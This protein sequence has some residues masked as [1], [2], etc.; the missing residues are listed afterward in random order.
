M[1][2]RYRTRKRPEITI[3]PINRNSS[4]DALVVG[5]I[6]VNSD[7]LEKKENSSKISQTTYK[8]GKKKKFLENIQMED[9]II[10][11]III[12]LLLKRNEPDN[13]E[14]DCTEE[15]NHG[16]SLEGL[17]K[18]LPLDKLSENDILLALMIYL[19]F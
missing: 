5:K 16:F 4:D 13:D 12:M 17:R 14:I 19:L 3:S 11:G 9:I 7:F 1:K 6:S 8:R 15:N 2:R 18:M 10:F